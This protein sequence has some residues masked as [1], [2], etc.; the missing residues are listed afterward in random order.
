VIDPGPAGFT[1][2][3][4]R[5]I[6]RELTID[7]STEATVTHRVISRDEALRLLRTQTGHF[8]RSR[9]WWRA[10]RVSQTIAVQIERR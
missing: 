1:L 10:Y 9:S 2:S 6:Y 8:G 5:F 7:P 3:P 4:L